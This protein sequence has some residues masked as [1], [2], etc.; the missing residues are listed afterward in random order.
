MTV[1]DKRQLTDS[2]KVTRKG[3]KDSYGK[4]EDMEPIIVTYCRFD[5]RRTRTGT[6]NNATESKPGVIIIYPQHAPGV[7]VDDSWHEATVEDHTG[8]YKVSAWQPNYL[9]GRLFSYE[10]EVV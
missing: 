2:V 6:N 10:V 8:T 1:I 4:A 7:V 5:R 9:H 3:P